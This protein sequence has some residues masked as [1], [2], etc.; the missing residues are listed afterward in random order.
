MRR[1][2]V[3]GLGGLCAVGNT[4]SDLWQ[5]LIEGRNGIDTITRFDISDFKVTLAAELRDFDPTVYM[6][7]SEIRKTDLFVQYAMAAACQAMD[8]SG[9]SDK[10]AA[11]RLGVYFGSG[12]GGIGAT[13]TE[14]G[15]LLEKG[16]RRVSAHCITMMIAN[17]AAGHIAIRF[18][19]KGSCL[20][21]VT[22]C[23]TSANAIGEAVR[24]IRHGYLDAVIAGGSEASIV[25]LGMA[26]FANMT[27]MTQS[28]DKNA[29]SI[30]FDAR[31][32]GFVMGEGAG[33]LILEEYEHAKARGAAIYCEVAGYG[34]NCDAHHITAPD[35]EAKGPAACI[36]MALDEAGECGIGGHGKVYINAHGTSTPLNDAME[37]QAIKLAFGERTKTD[38]LV[39]S[40]K[41]MTGHTLGAAGAI[42]AIAAILALKHGIVPPTIGLTEPD[43]VCD[44]DYVPLTARK[45]NLDL[46][47]STSLGFGGHNA[48][49]AFR[50]IN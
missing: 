11:E 35:P 43:P 12:I 49:L 2:V 33:A 48:C 9:I 44:L 41:S 18:G 22:A 47:L 32:S 14:V 10:I 40:T 16:P 1:V 42:E 45:T 28:T 24:T 7:K 13:S 3:T 8:E 5:S 15:R 19:A 4:V 6:E 17:L 23:A 38:V 50:E 37:T 34:T 27:A 46:A 30:P 25:P 21:V 29:A 36:Q 26:G 20:P 39:S 31:R